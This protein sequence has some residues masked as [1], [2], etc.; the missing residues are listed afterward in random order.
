MLKS[1][2][3]NGYSKKA[4]IPGYS[5]AGKTGTAQLSWAVYDIDRR[6]YSDKTM[7]SFIGY[8][9]FPIQNFLSWFKLKAPAAN[10]A[11]YSAMPIFHALAQEI[12]YLYQL[13]PKKIPAMLLLG[14]PH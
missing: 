5:I 14:R 2:I 4:K 12:I 9:R 1:V 8:F 11:E 6:G 7:Q 3:D 10:T 13:R